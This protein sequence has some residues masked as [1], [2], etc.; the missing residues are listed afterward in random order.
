M[1]RRKTMRNMVSA[2][3][4]ACRRSFSPNVVRQPLLPQTEGLIALQ[5]Q[6][7]RNCRKLPPPRSIRKGWALLL[8]L[9]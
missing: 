9:L 3:E 1:S 6:R 2:T 8:D 7:R 4:E 5:H